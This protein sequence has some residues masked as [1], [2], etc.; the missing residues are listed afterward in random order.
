MLG[1]DLIKKI[2]KIEAKVPIVFCSEYHEMIED[3]D[4][5]FYDIAAFLQKPLEAS[6]LED[7]IKELLNYK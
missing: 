7:K 5:R 4:M 2:R 6:I 1:L 3:D